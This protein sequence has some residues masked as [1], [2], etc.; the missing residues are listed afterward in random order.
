MSDKKTIQQLLAK[1][2]ELTAE[3]ASLKAKFEKDI[4]GR[5]HAEDTLD[6]FFSLSL[7][8]FFFM[9]LDEPIEWNDTTDKEKAL[10]Y[11]FAH[12]RI[13]KIN[14]AMLNQY[15]ATR[16]EFI[17]LTPN[18]FFSYDIMYGRKIWRQF[19]DSG[20]LHKETDE[21]R[22]DGTQMWVEGDYICLYDDQK[23]ITGHFGVQRDVTERAKAQE[24][25][26]ILS[27]TLLHNNAIINIAD[28]NDD[29][30][31]VNH[32]FCKA[33]GYT[34]KE[35]IGKNSS[36]FW[37]ERNP[38][39]VVEQILPATLQGGWKGELYN[40]RKDGSE[41]PIHLS[42]SVIK[43]DADE[44]IALVGIVEDIT[45]Q[46]RAENERQVLFDIMHAITTTS[47]LDDLLYLVHQSLKKVIYAENFF[48]ALYDQETGLFSF[49]YFADKFDPKPEP[50]AIG[51]SF[52]AYVFRTGE[53]LLFTQES[54]DELAARNEVELV[55]TWSPSWVGIPLRIPSRNIGVLVLQHYEDANIYTDRDIAYLASI[56]SQI[57]IAIDRKNTENELRESEEMF[58]RLFDESNDATLL[59]DEKGFANCNAAAVALFKFSSKNDL[60]FKKP[61][62]LSPEHQPDGLPSIVKAKMMM[63]KAIVQG[64]NRF[65]WI[66][67]KSDGSELPVEVM[68]TPIK[69]KGKEILYTVL[70]DITE[71]KR[72][73]LEI[74]QKNEQLNELITTRNKLFS[75]IAHDLKSPFH[76][77]L[78]LT[79]ILAENPE[80]FSAQELAKLGGNMHLTAR[81]LFTLLKNLLEWAQI[82]R[83][84]FGYSPVEIFLPDLITRIL[85]PMKK[86]AEQKNIKI[87]NRATKPIYVIADENML[88]SIVL[89]LLSNAVKFTKEQGRVTIMAKKIAGQMVEVSVKDTGI[90]MDENILNNLFKTGEK[91]SRQGT[92]D[93]LSTGLGLLLC[94]E[95]IEI[96]GGK[97]WATSKEHQGSTFCFTLHE[98]TVDVTN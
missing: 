68:L 31:F 18:D 52:T 47:N 41:F 65:E 54:F 64:Y 62:E 4:A 59:L 94:K 66:H 97:I 40:K 53:P 98:K 27:Q 42:T 71:R 30:L 72:S 11:A 92:E 1:I 96:N 34:E 21:R 48:V 50:S 89:N 26:K 80:N 15:R 8:G 81:N 57:A 24:Q 14:D 87:I 77:F 49:P 19:F 13:T 95:F 76:G 17:G 10:D 22:F 7:D 61:W 45:E 16:E 56:G 20:H 33:Y 38:R 32:A 85:Q 35:L 12:H 51:K 29:I 74:R 9:M 58:R 86:R 69:I 90:G 73:E 28:M 43:N 6:L 23:R 55:G 2:E 39:E 91:T 3:N 37:S 46:S 83:G 67:A 60:I 78:G 84:S 93:E 63:E 36:L 88:S 5:T 25:M 70:R 44:P 79:Q 75:I 82:Q